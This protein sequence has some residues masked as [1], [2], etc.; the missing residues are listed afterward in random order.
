MLHDQAG[1]LRL[2]VHGFQVTGHD[3]YAQ[4]ATE[5]VEYVL[6]DLGLDGGGIASAEDADS[7]TP[8]GRSAEGEFYVFTPDE[9]RAAVGPELAAAAIEHWEFDRPA[10]FEGRWIPARTHHRGR[11]A[12]RRSSSGLARCCSSDGPGAHAPGSTTRC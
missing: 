1:L 12:R 7:P 6:R 9:V 5:T 11:W 4:V 2:Y 10:N 8:D 3:R